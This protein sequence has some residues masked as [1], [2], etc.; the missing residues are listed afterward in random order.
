MSFRL[1]EVVQPLINRRVGRGRISFCL[2]AMFCRDNACFGL[3][4]LTSLTMEGRRCFGVLDQRS[5]SV[6]VGSQPDSL[7]ALLSLNSSLL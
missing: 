1:R 7:R 4:A 5:A 3:A 6:A 2:A